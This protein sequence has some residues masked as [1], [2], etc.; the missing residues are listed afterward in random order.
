MHRISLLLAVLLG[1]LASAEQPGSATEGDTV[2][3]GEVGSLTGPEA[4]FG[5]SARNGIEL[6]IVQVLCPLR[7]DHFL[8][9][10]PLY[11]SMFLLFCVFDAVAVLDGGR[12]AWV[13]AGR[14]V[15]RSV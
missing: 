15:S 14:S 7:L 8:A 4:S 3:I 9:M 12:P 1:A 2:W 13:A 11:V 6:A 5:I 10:A